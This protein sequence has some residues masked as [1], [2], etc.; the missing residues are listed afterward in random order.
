V[1]LRCAWCGSAIP[2]SCRRC[3]H[4]GLRA[5]V[6]GARR[7]AEELGRAFPGVPVLTS[8]GSEVL[9]RVGG[10]PA[11]VVATPGGEP[12]AEGGYAGAILLDGWA[13][14][15]L[16]SLRAAEEALRRWM[17]AAALVRSVAQGG[18]VVVVADAAQPAV[19]ALIR[20]DPATFAERELA[21]RAELR[22]PPVARMAS[23]SGPPSAVTSLLAATALPQGA[24]LLGP[25]AASGRPAARKQS[26]STQADADAPRTRP[27]PEP[28]R[29]LVRVP[30][31]EGTELALALRSGQ[32][33]RSA[34]K[35]PGAV[36]VQLDPA[37][38][39]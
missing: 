24:E 10:D 36:R 26:A 31:S 38:L 35:E 32:A 25:L 9:D 23:L 2:R 7:T 8:G 29:Y 11:V 6:T 15:G 16:A 18:T 39:I 33:A 19:Q 28:V 20:W 37:E 14:L 1:P 4:Q 13:M 22:F 5:L 12:V 34:A 3:G 27:S 30:R 21:E 17:N